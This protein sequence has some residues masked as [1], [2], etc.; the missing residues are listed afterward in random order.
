MRLLVGYPG[1][2]QVAL[3][4][5]NKKTRTTAGPVPRAP[6]LPPF[7]LRSVECGV[8]LALNAGPQTLGIM[9][10]GAPQTAPTT[11]YSKKHTH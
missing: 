2:A 1:M 10:E 5:Q 9:K 3:R 8:T 6:V 7:S 11:S 4:V